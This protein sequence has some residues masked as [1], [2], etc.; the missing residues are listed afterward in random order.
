MIAEV[1]QPYSPWL[2][3]DKSIQLA[4][5]GKTPGAD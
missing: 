4:E 3:I 2:N 1:T 5:A